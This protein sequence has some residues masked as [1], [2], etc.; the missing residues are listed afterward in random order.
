M[1][2]ILSQMIQSKLHNSNDQARNLIDLIEQEQSHRDVEEDEFYQ[3]YYNERLYQMN[4]SFLQQTLTSE[5]M[6]QPKLSRD[7]AVSKNFA[8]TFNAIVSDSERDQSI[9]Y[10]I[11]GAPNTGKSTFIK[12][13]ILKQCDKILSKDTNKSST[14]ISTPFYIDCRSIVNINVNSQV[15]RNIQQ[16]GFIKYMIEQQEAQYS[17]LLIEE[18]DSKNL[19][20]YIDGIDQIGQFKYQVL[21]IIRDLLQNKQLNNVVICLRHLLLSQLKGLDKIKIFQMQMP[22]DALTVN[23]MRKQMNSGQFEKFN[24]FQKDVKIIQDESDLQDILTICLP[25]IAFEALTRNLKDFSE[26]DFHRLQRFNNWK[27]FLKTI[28]KPSIKDCQRL[29]FSMSEQICTFLDAMNSFMINSTLDM[30]RTTHMLSKNASNKVLIKN[31]QSLKDKIQEGKPYMINDYLNNSG[32]SFISETSNEDAKIET[33]KDLNLD[34]GINYAYDTKFPTPQRLSLTQMPTPQDIYQ[35]AFMDNNPNNIL[36][37]SFVVEPISKEYNSRNP[38]IVAVES[39]LIEENEEAITNKPVIGNHGIQGITQSNLNIINQE[40]T[41]IN[42]KKLQFKQN[43]SNLPSHRASGYINDRHLRD[44][45][46]HNR[47]E[48]TATLLMEKSPV[49]T[50]RSKINLN[51]LMDA[52]NNLNKHPSVL[53]FNHKKLDDEKLRF[54][55]MMNN[56]NLLQQLN[57]VNLPISGRES[58]LSLNPYAQGAIDF[59]DEEGNINRFQTLRYLEKLLVIR[60]IKKQI[61]YVKIYLGLMISNTKS[62]FILNRALSIIQRFSDVITQ[63][64]KLFKLTLKTRDDLIELK[65]KL[66][67]KEDFSFLKVM[68]TADIMRP[69]LLILHKVIQKLEPKSIQEDQL[70]DFILIIDIVQD[71][72]TN[73][74]LYKLKSRK[75]HQIIFD[76]SGETNNSTV[77]IA[78][79]ATKSTSNNKNSLLSPTT[80]SK[81]DRFSV[82]TQSSQSNNFNN[83]KLSS[84]SKRTINLDKANNIQKMSFQ[85]QQNLKNR[86]QSSSNTYRQG[87]TVRDQSILF[88]PTSAKG[89]NDEKQRELKWKEILHKDKKIVEETAIKLISIFIESDEQI[90]KNKTEKFQFYVKLIDIQVLKDLLMRFG[91]LSEQSF[92]TL[93]DTSQNI[94]NDTKKDTILLRIDKNIAKHYALKQLTD[95]NLDQEKICKVIKSFQL[96]FNQNVINLNSQILKILSYFVDDSD[97]KVQL[98][99]LQTLNEILSYYSNLEITYVITDAQSQLAAVPHVLKDRIQMFNSDDQTSYDLLQCQIIK[100]Q[101][102]CCSLLY[103]IFDSH[104]KF[105]QNQAKFQNVVVENQNSEYFMD[106]LDHLVSDYIIKSFF[107][108]QKHSVQEIVNFISLLAAD[109]NPTNIQLTKLILH[110][111]LKIIDY[112]NDNSQIQVIKTVVWKVIISFFEDNEIKQVA[113][114]IVCSSISLAHELNNLIQSFININKNQNSSELIVLLSFK[115]LLKHISIKRTK[116]EWDLSQ[117][118]MS[119]RQSVNSGVGSVH[120]KLL[121][122]SSYLNQDTL[123][124]FEL[125][126][127]EQKSKRKIPMINQS[128]KKTQIN[129]S[130]LVEKQSKLSIGV[131]SANIK[132]NPAQS[133]PKSKQ[134]SELIQKISQ[135]KSQTKE[136]QIVNFQIQNINQSLYIDL[137]SVDLSK[138]LEN[139]RVIESQVKALIES[140]NSGVRQPYSPDNRNNQKYQDITIKE[141]NL[142]LSLDQPTLVP[143]YRS[144]MASP[145]QKNMKRSGDLDDFP[146]ANQTAKRKKEAP[147]TG[148][149]AQFKRRSGSSTNMGVRKFDQSFDKGSGQLSI[150][151]EIDFRDMDRLKEPSLQIQKSVNK[152]SDHIVSTKVM[153]S[154]SQPRKHKVFLRNMQ[155]YMNPNMNLHINIQQA[156]KSPKRINIQDGSVS[157]RKQKSPNHLKSNISTQNSVKREPTPTKSHSKME[158]TYK[159]KI[160]VHSQQQSQ[161]NQILSANKNNQQK[162]VEESKVLN[163]K[164]SNPHERQKV[165]TTFQKRDM[166]FEVSVSARGKAE[167]QYLENGKYLTTQ[168]QLIND[169]QEDGSIRGINSNQQREHRQSNYSSEF[170]GVKLQSKINQ[171]QQI[172]RTNNVNR[173]QSSATQKGFMSHDVY[174]SSSKVFDSPQSYDELNYVSPQL[175]SVIKKMEIYNSLFNPPKLTKELLKVLQDNIVGSF[176]DKSLQQDLYLQYIR[177]FEI[178]IENFILDEVKD[179]QIEKVIDGISE[180]SISLL[181]KTFQLITNEDEVLIKILYKLEILLNYDSPENSQKSQIIRQ[182]GQKII[183]GLEDAKVNIYQNTEQF[184]QVLNHFVFAEKLQS[185]SRLNQDEL[186][187]IQS[188]CINS[189][190]TFFQVKKKANVFYVMPND[191]FEWLFVDQEYKSGMVKSNY[192]NVIDCLMEIFKQMNIFSINQL[193]INNDQ[194]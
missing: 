166:S 33:D 101:V 193:E 163:V 28:G 172:S 141:N 131:R 34:I 168:E 91:F 39:C 122:T 54:N 74:E 175:Q 179:T 173:L 154:Q 167:S 35:R 32:Y 115:Q 102:R 106:S 52:Y 109:V 124:R 98:A 41:V 69:V 94:P 6:P 182:I 9:L 114:D 51:A 103:L 83:S 40:V 140:L 89:N 149:L 126:L 84:V 160:I 61:D 189:L 78:S 48:S 134:S 10:V 62:I 117:A 174:D 188:F 139:L 113:F 14:Q 29:L 120:E 127:S 105:G 2:I 110:I 142:I 27:K 136:P 24:Q 135:S 79:S 191:V 96:S 55:L 25:A 181:V 145:T 92:L 171:F 23:N 70:N 8:L 59:E 20:V 130:K 31:K 56:Q 138:R 192:E 82:G 11:A 81:L 76:I 137:N 37:Q 5:H 68:P 80:P 125:G 119:Y 152:P 26:V 153:L 133:Q 121:D 75:E 86:S 3:Q 147:K 42:K 30:N 19:L 21:Q 158:Q 57:M 128:L 155:K 63:H 1:P 194:N 186:T 49:S 72:T 73:Q 190:I 12:Q 95:Q 164:A 118:Q 64:S 112:V 17:K 116:L 13:C 93:I 159:S 148:N 107:S 45:G 100:E 184:K 183:K 146:L 99:A 4:N 132:L 77:S 150:K 58:A 15:K 85:Q 185:S 104:K 162:P 156:E 7:S 50:Q 16:K 44:Q 129:M 180:A 67:L 161:M 43:P 90:N 88:S 177:L 65:Y 187:L 87:L 97:S 46:L 170:S 151:Q 169:G 71:F 38:G 53:A 22:F 108:I 66:L 47:D 36:L 165:Y 60:S 144:L 111:I 123:R 143:Q 157:Q 18:Y 176:Q 178:M